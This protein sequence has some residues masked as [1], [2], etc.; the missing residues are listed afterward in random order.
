MVA[1]S[2]I[3]PLAALIPSTVVES[4][5]STTQRTSRDPKRSTRRPHGMQNKEPIRVAQRLMAA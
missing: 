1:A 4:A 3:N 2:T 5:A